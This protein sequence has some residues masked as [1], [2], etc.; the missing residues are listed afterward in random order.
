VRDDLQA[1]REAAERLLTDTRT[2]GELSCDD[3]NERFEAAQRVIAELR[4]DAERYRWLRDEH[5]AVAE[6]CMFITPDHM[7]EFRFGDDLDA[8]IDAARGN[9]G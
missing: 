9:G 3:C 6:S 2:C 8:A 1:A 4:R 5:S 7:A